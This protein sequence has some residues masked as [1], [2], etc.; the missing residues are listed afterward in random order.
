MSYIIQDYFAMNKQCR[1]A[2]KVPIHTLC[3]D[4]LFDFAGRSTSDT[5][6]DD[7]DEQQKQSNTANNDLK[8]TN[9]GAQLHVYEP[10]N[11]AN[12][13]FS[14]HAVLLER[15]IERPSKYLSLRT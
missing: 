6:E 1:S 11:S 12:S 7:T 3:L 13:T 2:T 4:I 9:D 14:K 10:D 5:V 8:Q 15:G